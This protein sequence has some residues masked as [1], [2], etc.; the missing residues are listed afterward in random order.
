MA[1]EERNAK[2]W[3]KAS[4]DPDNLIED[5]ERPLIFMTKV[6][7]YDITF[8]YATICEDPNSKLKLLELFV[9]H[10]H[11]HQSFSEKSRIGV[12]PVSSSREAYNHLEQAAEAD[13]RMISEDMG[14]PSIGIEIRT[15]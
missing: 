10:T 11:N 5:A 9:Q 8:H 15:K 4:G 13:A 6:G 2:V 3:I 12:F 7:G 14:I 1:G